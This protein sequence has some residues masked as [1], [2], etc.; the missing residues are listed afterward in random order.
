MVLNDI[1]LEL[2]LDGS[3]P[4]LSPRVIVLKEGGPLHIPPFSIAFWVF[5]DLKSDACKK[6]F[7]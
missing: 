4:A 1:P 3:I 7:S 5:R 2:G 6:A